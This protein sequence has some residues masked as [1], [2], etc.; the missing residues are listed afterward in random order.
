M[1]TQHSCYYNSPAGTIYMAA[2][3]IGICD[4]HFIREAV[5]VSV[6]SEK[7]PLLAELTIQL[8]NYFA[9]KLKSFDIPLNPSGTDF[10]KQVWKAV[11]NIPYGEVISYAKLSE[12][13]GNAGAIRAVANANAKNPLL[14]LV[15]CHRVIGSNKSLTGYSGGLPRK[16][17]LLQLEGYSV[18][19]EQLSLVL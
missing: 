17:F 18:P 4:L 6:N 2:N 5:S 3:G 11:A 12:S 8:D 14:I 15:P 10:Q 9:G 13:L 1:E 7:H 19:V 16:R